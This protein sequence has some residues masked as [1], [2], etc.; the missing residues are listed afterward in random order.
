MES[1]KI[2]ATSKYLP[3][4]KVENS[5]FDSKFNLEDEWISKRTG[6]ENRFFTKDE[7]I[8]DLAINVAK[9]I[10]EKIDFDIQKIGNIIVA[11]TSSDR[12][13][14]GISFEIQKALDIKKCMCL[15]I[16]AGCSGFINAFD[17]ARKNIILNETECALVIGVETISKFLDFD[18]VNTAVLLGDGAGAV[19]LEKSNI[20]KKYISN[21]ESIGQDGEILTCHNGERLYMNGKAIYKYAVSKV[22][23]N[24]ENTLE[25]SNEKIENLKCI[26]PHQ[27]NIRILESISKK[28]N[29]SDD[30]MYC[31]LKRIGNT[32]CASIPIAL[33]DIFENLKSG[34]KVILVRIWWWIKLRKYTFGN[35]AKYLKINK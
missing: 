20:V 14:P 2:I 3:N 34:D 35:I 31:N 5:F 9:R 17:I 1:I 30:K 32:F 10:V 26:V 8:V 11:S 15:D 18:D 22:T 24:I 7:N 21:I 25:R 27:S 12:I 28:L 33:D 4:N 19:L 29:I 16:S 13:M 6:V 23:E